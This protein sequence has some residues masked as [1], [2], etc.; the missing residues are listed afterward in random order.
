M[1][2]D[3]WPKAKPPIGWGDQIWAS[4]ANQI[5]GSE[6][7]TGKGGGGKIFPP[8]ATSPSHLKLPHRALGTSPV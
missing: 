7:P 5:Q 2:V 1:K 4:L 6:G 3:G 8:A